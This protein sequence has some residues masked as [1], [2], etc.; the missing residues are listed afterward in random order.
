MGALDFANELRALCEKHQV[1]MDKTRIWV[2]SEPWEMLSA[3]GYV[4]SLWNKD[5]V[6]ITSSQEDDDLL[7]N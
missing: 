4:V 6:N 1:M 3:D 7:D 2:E 5:D